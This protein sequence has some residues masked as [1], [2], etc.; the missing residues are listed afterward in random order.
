VGRGVP[1]S[2]LDFDQSQPLDPMTVS[3]VLRTTTNMRGMQSAS[4]VDEILSAITLCTR[5]M[6]NWT[7]VLPDAFTAAQLNQ[8]LASAPT[9]AASPAKTIT[10]AGTAGWAA[11]SAGEKT[12]M[13][14]AFLAKGYT[15]N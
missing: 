2:A 14:A 9:V 11:L 8:L 4:A 13:T 3:G 6:K 5:G 12:A 7:F 15:Q 1:T 10:A